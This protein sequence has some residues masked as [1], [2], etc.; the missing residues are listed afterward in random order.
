MRLALIPGL[1]LALTSAA[2][3]QE[4]L[5]PFDAPVV[6]VS[7]YESIDAV[8][9]LN[10]DGIRD[11]IG[12]YYKPSSP[13]YSEIDLRTRLGQ[14]DGT[15]ATSNW[16]TIISNPSHQALHWEI[17][18]GHLNGD[19]FEDFVVTVDE[20]VWVYKSSPSGVP[21]LLATWT[22]AAPIKG[23]VV[24]DFDQ[25]GLD[26]IATG[27]AGVILRKSNGLAFPVVATHAT[28]TDLFG[29]DLDGNGSPDLLVETGDAVQLLF[30]SGTTITAGPTLTHG[31]TNFPMITC[32]D[33]TGDALD[34]IVV[35]SMDE[36]N[37]LIKQV[38]AGSFSV[39]PLRVGGPATN[40][41]DIDGDGDLDGVCCS[42]GGPG[43]PTNI[44]SSTYRA[45]LN[46]GDGTFDIA[47]AI[48]GLGAKRLADAFDADADGDVDLVAG[49]VV[50]FNRDSFRRPPQPEF[51][52]G[53]DGSPIHVIDRDGD[54]DPDVVR[55]AAGAFFD[56]DGC[57]GF[58]AITP[59]FPTL[60]SGHSF[61]G[62]G[63][64]GDF[65]ADSDIDLIV[66]ELDG[67][68][69]VG[70]R[71][72]WNAGGGGYADGG[73]ALPLG[74]AFASKNSGLYGDRAVTG[75]IDGDG[76]LDVVAGNDVGPIATHAWLGD[77]VGGFT[78]KSTFNTLEPLALVDFDRD[79]HLDAYTGYGGG[80]PTFIH[81]GAGDGTFAPFFVMGTRVHDVFDQPAF[82]DMNGD[83]LT[84]IVAVDR[85][86]GGLDVWLNQ[87]NRT[88]ALTKL[89]ITIGV[90]TSSEVAISVHAYDLDDDGDRDVIASNPFL[91]AGV[92]LILLNDGTGTL[93]PLIEQVVTASGFADVDGDGDVDA[94]GPRVARHTRFHVPTDGL[95][96]QYGANSSGLGGMGPKLGATGPFRVGESINLRL[97]GGPGASWALMTLGLGRS[98]LADWPAPG[99]TAYAYPPVL[100]LGL[101]LDGNPGEAGT[102]GFSIPAIVP[103]VAAGASFTF[104]AFVLDQTA[105][106]WWTQ[107]N[108]LELSFE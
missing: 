80:G 11:G 31:I 77:G 10:G 72:L 97:S 20:T 39:T 12:W 46:K 108:G 9:D 34:D 79:G 70:M 106:H 24:A 19:V 68:G 101:S 67:S 38:A 2:P 107:T 60:P 96:E 23:L 87:G 36:T 85:Y 54:G 15:F 37:V 3:A 84:D 6:V 82:D 59:V 40:L 88:F 5:S 22:E 105:P 74:T 14:G 71:M 103:P 29:G 49:R 64:Q 100:S 63:I 102:G 53:H 81:F 62:P 8:A 78:W 43:P 104:Q 76:H 35:F 91:G 50:M 7:K 45:A 51:D 95:R 58:S 69:F 99:L 32:G 73:F 65:D 28:G 55:D 25:D 18:T 90:S 57:G 41:A 27:G 94:V 13:Y 4:A 42:S 30:V 48:T 44:E 83:G 86:A 93:T 92:S 1:L 98:D 17:E 16:S 89:D 33:V 21:V 56:N 52:V 75:D 47:Y 61:A 66:A 26:D